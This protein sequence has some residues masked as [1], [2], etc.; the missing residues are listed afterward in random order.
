MYNFQKEVKKMNYCKTCDALHQEIENYQEDEVVKL[1][2]NLYCFIEDQRNRRYLILG[3]ERAALIDTGYSVKNPWKQIRSITNLPL[4]VI[5]THGDPDHALGV[6]WY[7]N[8]YIHALD[9]KRILDYEKNEAAK[10]KS[11]NHFHKEDQSFD[12]VKDYYIS[13]IIQQDQFILIEDQDTI[14]LGDI[15]LDIIH[16]PAHTFGSV[17]ILD[18]KGRN[19]F[20]G[21]NASYDDLW[22]FC[23]G[24]RVPE[25]SVIQK[26]YQYLKSFE[27]QYDF[28]WGAHGK[29]PL[30]KEIIDEIIEAIDD[31]KLHHQNDEVNPSR[32]ISSIVAEEGPA[33][34]HFYKS[35]KLVYTKCQLE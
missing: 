7:S 31:V 21:D 8:A 15:K 34:N 33:Y 18:K 17:A 27:S 32:F 2:E 5:C 20:V 14:D 25:F 16:V 11:F 1:S 13:P 9:V 26:S 10:L 35:V 23:K 30:H 22:M 28:I 29:Q 6:R 3:S 19:L 12:N 24:V 4:M